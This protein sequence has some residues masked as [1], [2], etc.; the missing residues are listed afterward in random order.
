MTCYSCP[1]YINISYNICQIKGRQ[2]CFYIFYLFLLLN[3]FLLFAQLDLCSYPYSVRHYQDLCDKNVNEINIYTT[4]RKYTLSL[5][6][7]NEF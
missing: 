1:F 2:F 3:L 6:Q 4:K 7:F 5:K